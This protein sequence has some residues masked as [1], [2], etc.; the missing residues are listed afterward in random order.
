MEFIRN[1]LTRKNGDGSLKVQPE[2][3][4]SINRSSSIRAH[5]L[6][7]RVSSIQSSDPSL[8]VACRQLNLSRAYQ[9]LVTSTYSPGGVLLGQ[10]QD[11]PAASKCP[12]CQILSL[13]CKETCLA[14]RSL[15][16]GLP[17]E[18][19]AFYLL[20]H[21]A[22]QWVKGG[23]TFIEDRSSDFFVA[24]VPSQF[25]MAPG[26]SDRAMFDD[27]VSKRGFLVYRDD[28]NVEDRM[29][30]PR[31]ITPHFDPCVVQDWLHTCVSQHD[32]CRLVQRPQPSLNLID[33]Q[34]PYVV[35][36]VDILT[37]SDTMK[38]RIG[39]DFKNGVF[40]TE[41]AELP[42]Y[43][44]LSYVWGHGIDVSK[45]VLN[46][47]KLPEPLPAVVEDAIVVVLKLGYRYLWVDK[48][49][50][51]N[52]DK[53]VK[54]EQ[55]MHMDSIYKNAA[56]TIV[57]AAGADESY[58]LPG[59][60]RLRPGRQL[61]LKRDAESYALISTLPL[62]HSAIAK[63]KWATRGW[64]Y[65][66]AILS[67]R[68]LVFTD[69]Q[70]YFE[71]NSTC[72]A[73]GF[74]MSFDDHLLGSGTSHDNNFIRPSLFS[75]KKLAHSNFD[76]K[77]ARLSNFFTYVHCAEQYSKRTLSFDHDSLLA[78]G[79]IIKVLESTTTFPVRHIWGIPFFH[80]DDDNLADD[81][82]KMTYQSFQLRPF[83]KS[84]VLK[85]NNA[86]R[87][88]PSDVGVDYL[89]YLMLGLSWRHSPSVSPRRRNDLP[90]WS[91]TG[92]E[93]SLIWP[94]LTQN[95]D[96]RSAA[97]A[98]TAISLGP[99][100]SDYVPESYHKSIDTHLLTQG[101]KS[102]HI[103]TPAISRKAFLFDESSC[104]L[105]LS[106]GGDVKLYPSKNGLDAQK[107]FKRIQSGR[108]EVIR[109]AT[110]DE[111]AYM[112]LMKRYHNSYYRIGTMAVKDTYLTYSL[113]TSKIN[114]YK[115][116]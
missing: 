23:K 63:S 43:V 49:C 47:S 25:S 54:H 3:R 53:E 114:T 15:S 102:L 68:R 50:I 62:P 11:D 101:N 61:S 76:G 65:Q 56:L 44:A 36:A 20:P 72:Y 115:L 89:A 91:W 59:L 46:G 81:Q 8:C 18:L 77:A 83:S 34:S 1:R 85:D 64:T 93:G 32:G 104:T 98:E 92:W 116:R 71:C 14:T 9:T 86:P 27:M 84:P 28:R 67:R 31:F 78:F 40:T 39:R 24:A 29:L 26:D 16:Y 22:A 111:D 70:L 52:H 19:R 58:G 112:M 113:F 35:K 108:Y 2:L 66:E 95:S 30:K 37:G 105:A 38:D 73:E 13:V 41:S 21:L 79:G 97:W 6:G 60:S 7:R 82:L 12:L 94:E 48:Y 87:I 110:V 103:R 45:V 106:T 75:L 42:E 90:S 33:C 88:L 74:D 96:I 107:V 100:S 10:L 109:L 99:N 57:A 51:D 5:E 55:L 69:E 4:P 80:P 17:L